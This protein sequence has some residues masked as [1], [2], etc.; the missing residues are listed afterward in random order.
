MEFGEFYLTNVTYKGDTY[1]KVNVSGI[2]MTGFNGRY[3]IIGA[4]LSGDNLGGSIVE[5]NDWAKNYII[6]KP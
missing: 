6:I 5:Y 3:Y 2:K 1:S 4:V